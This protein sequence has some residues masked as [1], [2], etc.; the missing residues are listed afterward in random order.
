MIYD[1]IKLP[2]TYDALEP[3]LDATT[4][5]THYSKHLSGY[6]DKL[7]GILAN[8]SE[9]TEG[10]SLEDILSN[11]TMLPQEIRQAVINQGGGVFNHNL[12]FSLLSPNP[13]KA[14]EGKLLNKIVEDFSSLENLVEKLT[15]SAINQFG[16]GYAWLVINK[17]GD[18]EVI[19][20]SNQD[21][22]LSAGVKP[23]LTIDVWEHAYYLKYKN[24]RAEYVKNIWN[25]IDWQV[26]E[27][28]YNAYVA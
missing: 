1:K 16:S 10:K 27:N 2:F 14:P 5:E 6:V 18:L 15:N 13:K 17:K 19:S 4:V 9:I 21:C 8:H 7:N 26:V 3:Y 25:L 11:V 12:Y 22:P 20:T 23:I 28:L 24:L